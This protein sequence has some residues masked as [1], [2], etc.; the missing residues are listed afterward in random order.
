MSDDGVTIA[1]WSGPRNLSTALMYSFD[2]RADTQVWDEPFYAAYLGATGIDHPLRD[3][4][5][6]AY[7]TDPHVV[8]AHCLQQPAGARVF[9]QKHMTH[10]MVEGF[11]LDWME[12]V[13]N[14]FLI[15]APEAVIASYDAKRRRPTLDDL[16]FVRQHELFERMADRLGQAPPVVDADA[17]RRA[18]EP[19]L[20]R[21]C[22]AL[23]IPFDPAML[24][25]PAGPRPCDGLWASHWY[26]AIHRS[27][28]FSPSRPHRPLDAAELRL[29]EAAAPHH[30]ALAR[31]C[32]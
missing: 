14:A 10:H 28:G 31:W 27:T 29:A 3:E 7:E 11:P 13:R 17:V 6:N 32:V 22:A 23:D 8:A 9:Y 19:A 20:R 26:D 24:A 15:R 12:R 2:N 5:L 21:L 30:A 25:W 4:V 16:G 1:M 18:P